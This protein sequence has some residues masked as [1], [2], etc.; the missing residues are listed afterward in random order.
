MNEQATSITGGHLIG[1]ARVSTD[2][3]DL[4]NQ[5]A[6]LKA[7]GCTRIFEEKVS[8]VKRDRVELARMLDHLRPG[9]TVLVVRLD[10]LARSTRDL[11]DIAE[12]LREIGAGLR[13]LAEPWADTSSPAGKMILTVMAGIA[14]FER[15]LILERTGAGRKAAQA[16]GVKFG[17]SRALTD[18]QLQAAQQM[19]AQPGATVTSVAEAFKVN[20]STLYRAIA[21]LEE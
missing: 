10:R 21:S 14:D 13:S 3:Q 1:Y 5:R 20:R 12:R 17:R 18:S 4:A 19:I 11:L 15:S 16:R 2:G 6:S 8:G 7:E 9:D